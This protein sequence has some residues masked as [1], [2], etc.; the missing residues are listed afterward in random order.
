MTHEIG[1]IWCGSVGAVLGEKT[2]SI[3]DSETLNL[4]VNLKRRH[5]VSAARHAAKEKKIAKLI[6]QIYQVAAEPGDEIHYYAKE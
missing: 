3:K 4:A 5:D 1:H 6:H 2:I